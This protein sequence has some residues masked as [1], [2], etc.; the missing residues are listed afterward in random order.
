[1]NNSHATGSPEWVEQALN[2]EHPTRTWLIH[3]LDIDLREIDRL[4]AR[5]KE[6]E[7]DARSWRKIAFKIEAVREEELEES[8]N[9]DALMIQL[10]KE[11]VCDLEAVREAAEKVQ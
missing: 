3:K 6:L 8:K 9:K 5:V 10:L 4:R 2:S 11:T 7:E 1:M